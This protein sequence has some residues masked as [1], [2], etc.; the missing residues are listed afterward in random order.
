MRCETGVK[1]LKK[2]K[3]AKIV[4][5]PAWFVFFPIGGFP[6]EFER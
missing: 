4:K 2:T 1:D 3:Q 5:I 6:S